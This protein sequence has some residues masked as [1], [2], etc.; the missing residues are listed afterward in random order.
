VN[1]KPI[2]AAVAVLALAVPAAAIAAQPASH[3]STVAATG[4]DTSRHET[5]SRD[6]WEAAHKQDGS[7]DRSADHSSPDTSRDHSDG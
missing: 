5:A 7:A 2:A 1:R 6:R 3:A 4:H